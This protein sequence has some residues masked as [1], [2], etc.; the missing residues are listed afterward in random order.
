[1]SLELREGTWP[2]DAS[3]ERAKQHSEY[4]EDF[5]ERLSPGPSN[6][7]V[8]GRKEW[9]AGMLSSVGEEKTEAG[10]VIE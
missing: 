2:G 10:E 5:K 1:M 7:G 8:G 9:R 3:L 6:I 4:R